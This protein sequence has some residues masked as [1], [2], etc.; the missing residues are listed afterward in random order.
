[1]NKSLVNLIIASLLTVFLCV[2]CSGEKSVSD[3]V[4]KSEEP[5]IKHHYAEPHMGTIVR[6][7]FY[8]SDKKQ[9]DQL[10]RQ[11]FNRVKELNAKLSDYLPD[12]EVSQL[13][14]KPIGQPHG[15]SDEL[16]D[17]MIFG[18]NVSEKTNGAFDITFGK[19]SQ[20][21]RQKS[22]KTQTQTVNPEIEK[23][24]L[25]SYKDLIIDRK[26]KWVTL[27]K[28]LKIDLGAIGKGYIADEVM[29]LIQDS[30][31]TR[32]AVIIGGETVLADPPPEKKGWSIGIENPEK[33]IFGKLILRN[34]ALST[35]G[36]SYQFFENDG[37]PTKREAHLIDPK[38]RKGKS[39][40]LN[41][42]T[43]APTA[44]QADAW[45]TA[46]RILPTKKALDLANQQPNLEALFIPIQGTITK[47]ENFPT[48][49]EIK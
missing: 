34:T 12:S 48:I 6:I 31:I 21:W 3:E 47:T 45:A 7:V 42:T 40:R 36:D 19:H 13:S 30:N 2:S 17:I 26:N 44:M 25:T 1:M 15:V 33:K 11:C 16:L 28:P 38:T 5:L 43:I 23:S 20:R 14:E 27:K 10:A 22:N 49:S 35:S 4:V 39:N 18:Q 41:V 9:A 29:K 24:A 46:L 32:A 8:S 37:D